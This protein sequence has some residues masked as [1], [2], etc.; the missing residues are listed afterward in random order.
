MRKIL[1][2]PTEFTAKDDLSEQISSQ[3]MAQ[4]DEALVF[5]DA[6]MA[7]MDSPDPLLVSMTL[8]DS[9]DVFLNFDLSDRRALI[10]KDYDGVPLASYFKHLL[11][12]GRWSRNA[13][14]SDSETALQPDQVF[15]TGSPRIDFLRDL[16]AKR[17]SPEGPL[18]VLFCPLHSNW[19]DADGQVMSCDEEFSPLLPMLEDLCTVTK[20]VDQRNLPGKKPVTQELLDADVIITDYTSVMFEAWALGKP[21]IFP[22]WIA[23]NRVVIKA[24]KTAEAHVYREKIG[25]HPTSL[26][27]MRALL[28]QG[29]ELGLGEGVD[30][31]MDEYLYNY[32][33]SK[34]AAQTTA[35]TL[36]FIADE[37]NEARKG[38]LV[39]QANNA[40]NEGDHEAAIEY[41]K[42]A[43]DIA[44]FDPTLL[45][46]LA[47]SAH[48]LRQFPLEIEAL[49]RAA[50][51]EKFNARMYWRLGTAQKS[52]RQH[53]AAAE[54]Y[55]AA[56]A[57]ND[58][59]SYK[60]YYQLGYVLENPGHDGEP[61]IPAAKAAYEVAS[62]LAKQQKVSNNTVGDLHIL[63]GHWLEAQTAFEQ[64]IQEDPFHPRYHYCRGRTYDRT[65]QWAKAEECYRTALALKPKSPDWH[66]QLGFVLE[67]QGKFEEAAEAYLHAAP[68]NAKKGKDWYYRAGYV[69]EKL[70]KFKEACSAY[71]KSTTFELDLA[72]IADPYTEQFAERRSA[73]FEKWL[74]KNPSS[75]EVWQKFSQALEQDGD[76]A[77]ASKAHRKFML[78]SSSMNANDEKLQIRLDAP[79]R[80]KQFFEDRLAIDCRYAAEWLKY[81][82]LLENFGDLDG[83][84][85]AVKQAIWRTN[86]HDPKLF[87]RRGW[88]L[89]RLG[90]FEESCESFRHSHLLQRAHGTSYGGRFRTDLN[91][92]AVAIYR[93][94]FDELP[95]IKNTILYES[96]GGQGFSDN[97]LAMFEQARRDPRFE[98]WTHIWVV[99]DLEKV[100]AALHGEKDVFFVEKETTLYMRYLCTTEYLINN[101]T[102]PFYYVRKEGQK[103]L[104]TWH[105]TPLKT[106]GYDIEATPLQRANTAR[107]LIQ[108]S[109]FIA[110]NKHTE[111]V[112]IDRYGVRN[113]FT[114]RSMLSGYPRIDM[115]INA[116]KDDKEL[117]FEQLEL[118]PSKPVVLFAP[119]YRG[120]WATPELESEEL[121][122]LVSQMKSDDYN[123]V[124]RGH[125]FAQNTILEMGLPVTIAPHEIDTCKLLSIVDVLVSDYSSIFY[126]FLITGKPVI[127]YVYDWDYYVETRGV[128]FEKSALPGVICEDK[129]ALLQAL[130]DCIAEPDKHISAAYNAAKEAFCV[131]EDGKAS[132]RVIEALFFEEPVIV[133]PELSEFKGHLLFHCGELAHTATTISAQNL[134]RATKEAG[135]KN[136]M[137]VDRRM[138]IDHADRTE[139]A[140]GML[141]DTDVI[142]R[143][144]RACLSLEE[145]WVNDKFN[146]TAGYASDAMEAVH[147]GAMKHEARRLMGHASFDAAI[148][149]DGTRAFW[150]NLLSAANAKHHVICLN[151]NLKEQTETKFPHMANLQK[152]I[153]KYDTILSPTDALT[154]IHKKQLELIPG[155]RFKTL[156]SVIDV[157]S[158]VSRAADL[159]DDP[160]FKAFQDD[161]RL[162]LISLENLWPERE[163]A[164][165]LDAVKALDDKGTEISL[166]VLGQGPSHLAL[167]YDIAERNLKHCVHFIGWQDNPFPYLSN[168]DCAV[169]TSG[170]QQVALEAAALGTPCIAIGENDE[171]SRKMSKYVSQQVI[172]DAAKLAAAI[173][174]HSGSDAKPISLDAQ[175]HNDHVVKTLGDILT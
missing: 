19:F 159:P 35:Q 97:P 9:S 53:C 26:V 161:T 27:E 92:Q 4:I 130:K 93:E 158:L 16:A 68:Q 80:Q 124:F 14:L 147:I 156:G 119:T 98:G 54:S 60:W 165:I 174:K 73:L 90:K 36:E 30:A 157:T 21:V 166:Y 172:A 85:E 137:L 131:V 125:Y 10:Q 31:F 110:P 136:T 56:I 58:K 102:F 150:A 87:N 20:V 76:L 79:I 49:Q 141:D 106:L 104:N 148:E 114:G 94:F 38:T 86:E 162:K 121:A 134:L 51:F 5:G 133:P 61:D 160:A 11:V 105:G 7:D 64:Y 66:Y 37:R 163:F 128:Y 84:S 67:R 103:Y 74:K 132:E 2:A 69:L 135:Y 151:D 18:K 171:V 25:H 47:K 43:I 153:E 89:A 82:D 91:L 59:V 123:L 126:D 116:T 144:G 55:K 129:P 122:R 140:Q 75:S 83:A 50:A 170:R 96:F 32:D 138:I 127:H 48:S 145:A 52:M 71:L 65:Y 3:V 63:A 45:D 142:I 70:G 175:K 78:H 108:S 139:I 62:S 107:N 113:L 12:P 15:I 117:L 29:R 81:S 6:D 13:L 111:S 40:A 149:F 42:E 146:S 33:P 120:H 164:C 167:K 41:Y 88:L 112:M 115:M 99:D 24:A 168:A 44:P 152:P 1:F 77:G 28:E 109:L 95:I 154:E 155:D 100:P 39:F 173:K 169:S 46:G 22:R 8:K 17:P 101:A 57:L 34:N 118:D 143:F 23:G 72:E